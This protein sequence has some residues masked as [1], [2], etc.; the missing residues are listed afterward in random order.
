MQSLILGL[1]DIAHVEGL[2]VKAD[3]RV[4]IM[5]V[6]WP[7]S[8]QERISLLTLTIAESLRCIAVDNPRYITITTEEK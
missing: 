5:R 6:T 1:E 4:P 8:E 7:V 2:D 3:E